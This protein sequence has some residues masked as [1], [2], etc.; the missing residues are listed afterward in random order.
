MK[1]ER[2]ILDGMSD[3]TISFSIHASEGAIKAL[4]KAYCAKFGLTV[5]YWNGNH[6]GSLQEVVFN[7]SVP[8]DKADEAYTFAQGFV[9]TV[10]D[11]ERAAFNAAVRRFKEVIWDHR[12][13][14]D[15]YG[16]HWGGHIVGFLL[17][18]GIPLKDITDEVQEDLVC[19]QFDGYLKA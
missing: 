15:P 1:D 3:N 13:D 17:A 4:V 2:F 9:F 8:E 14:M 7:E 12:D 19:G 16:R 18:C 10:A 5:N 11:Q 6:D